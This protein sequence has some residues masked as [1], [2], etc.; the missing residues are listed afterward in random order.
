MLNLRR[1]SYGLD[2]RPIATTK[3]LAEY[4]L[5]CHNSG[6]GTIGNSAD[7][8]AIGY[9]LTVILDLRNE[10]AALKNA[11]DDHKIEGHTFEVAQDPVKGYR[12]MNGEER[13]AYAAAKKVD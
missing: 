11:L 13:A 10:V 6:M 1:F 9:L 3:A 4:R 8:P 12:H 5:V 2:G 7:G